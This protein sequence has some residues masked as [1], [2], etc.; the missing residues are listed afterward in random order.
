MLYIKEKLTKNL[1]LTIEMSE[2]LLGLTLIICTDAKQLKKLC[3]S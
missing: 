1:N 3:C 2:V